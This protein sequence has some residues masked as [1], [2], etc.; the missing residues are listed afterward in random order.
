MKRLIVCCDG[1][2]QK[3][4]SPYPTNVVK[5]AQ[6]IKPKANDET[7]QILY[8]DEG[9]GTA[10]EAD[11]LFGGAFGKGLDENIQD[12]YRF[13]CLNYVE[14][15]EIYLFGFSRGAYTVRSLAGLIYNSGLLARY[16]IRDIPKAY[17]LYCSRGSGP[18]EQQAVEFRQKYGDRVP[19]T[20]LGC[21]DTVGSL[22][23]PDLSSF[24]KFDQKINQKYRFHDTQL[25][26]M[27]KNALHAVA[28]DEHRKVFNV[29]PM[30]KSPNAEDQVLR[31]VWFAGDHGCVGGGSKE[32]CKLSDATLKWMIESICDIGLGLEF[33]PKNINP[34]I[35]IDYSCDFHFQPKTLMS[36]A[37]RLA[38]AI[39][40]EIGD[41]FENLH[42]GVIKRWKSRA[43]YRPENLKKFLKQLEG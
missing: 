3:L 8:Y 10:D 40:R 43:D 24:L 36:K 27:I 6:A 15:D 1:T 11:R 17:E 12:A 34:P 16:H 19:I 41:E 7:P 28:I 32:H 35:E 33:D 23:I 2:W 39:V 29:T 9:V 5:I 31:Q 26:R 42:E 14:G 18:S 37:T 21:W 20:L 4:T 22:G 30:Q 13:L 38:G 25:N